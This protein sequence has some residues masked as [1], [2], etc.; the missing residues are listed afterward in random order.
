MRL[1]KYNYKI[2]PQVTPFVFAVYTTLVVYT[3]QLEEYN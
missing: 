1:N 3:P 2:M